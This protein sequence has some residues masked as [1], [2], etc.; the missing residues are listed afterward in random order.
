MKLEQVGNYRIVG[1]LRKQGPVHWFRCQGP[2]APAVLHLLPRS[3][4]RREL[5][6]QYQRLQP[7]LALPEA[8]EFPTLLAVERKVEG[9]QSAYCA[10]LQDFDPSASLQQ[11]LDRQERSDPMQ[12]LMV[13]RVLARAL[14]EL[15]RRQ[16]AHGRIHAGNCFIIGKQL[17]VQHPLCAWAERAVDAGGAAMVVQHCAPESI[18]GGE[19]DL[20]GD[21]FSVGAVLYSLLLGHPPFTGSGFASMDTDLLSQMLPD[22]REERPELS[23]G[24]VQLLARCCAPDATARYQRMGDLAEDVESVIAGGLPVHATEA[25]GGAS[26]R[27]ASP[28]SQSAVGKISIQ[29]FTQRLLD[30]AGTGA[31]APPSP[32]T[33]PAPKRPAAPRVGSGPRPASAPRPVSAPRRSVHPRGERRSRSA[34]RS[35]MPLLVVLAVLALAGGVILALVSNESPAPVHAS[36]PSTD[37]HSSDATGE[38]DEQRR[39]DRTPT[40][41]RRDAPEDVEERTRYRRSASMRT[42]IRGSLSRR[43]RAMARSSACRISTPCNPCWTVCDPTS[44]YPVASP[45]TTSPCVSK[46]ISTCR[47]AATTASG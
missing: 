13:A 46:A 24:M 18:R 12:A 35:P 15:E 9:S 3:Q 45:A 30:S 4:E 40:W 23:A 32:S 17:L 14:L 42:C 1:A 47:S 2:D 27:D 6:A 10:V 25:A 37:E 22:P 29:D 8:P 36:Q 31:P 11:Y 26:V 34:G 43:I 20:R 44:G 7:S 41:L 21:V 28:D 39:V 38:S 16:L 19:I 33:A 5:D